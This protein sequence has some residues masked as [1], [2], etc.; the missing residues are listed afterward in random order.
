MEAVTSGPRAIEL[1][2]RQNFDVAV[3]DLK[4]P[5]MDGIEV[6]RALHDVQPYLQ[7]IML[8]GHGSI[9]SA[10]ESG[11]HNAFRFLVK[12]HEMEKLVQ[13]I[14]EAFDNRR[15]LLK[16]AFM[17]ELIELNSAMGSPM[18]LVESTNRLRAKYE[19]D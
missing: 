7:A 6:L 13:T 8:T 16:E 18:E 15:K 19:Q 4:M 14:Q 10:L 17:E 11:R 12:P 2:N 3:L 5:E 9:D 1:A